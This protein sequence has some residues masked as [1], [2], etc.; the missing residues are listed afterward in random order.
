[1]ILKFKIF[2]VLLVIISS[3]RIQEYECVC[4]GK[5]DQVS[6]DTYITKNRKLDAEKYCSSLSTNEKNCV[7]NED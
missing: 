7:I 2:L 1:M 4:Y 3:C 6:Y 5:E